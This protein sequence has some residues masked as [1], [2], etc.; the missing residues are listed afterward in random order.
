MQFDYIVIGG[1]LAGLYTSYLLSK[2][3]R[4]AL[5]ACATLEE[6]NSYFAQGGMA[7]V[8]EADDTPKSHF[9]DT[10]IAGRGLCREE[11]V[12]ILTQEAP[13]RIEEIITLGMHFDTEN[14]HLA[15]GLEGGHHHRR[16]LHAG[17]D[18]TGRMVTSFMTGLVRSSSSI[19]IFD[20]HFALEL[21]VED[22]VCYGV[23]T[24]DKENTRIESF[25]A[26]ATILATG[27][28]AALYQPTTNPPT[29]LGDGLA[30][31]LVAGAE[32]KDLE[33]VQFHPTALYIPGASSFLISEAVRGEGA[34]LYNQRGERFMLDKH[35]LA[36][37]APR[38]TVAREIFYQMEREGA[39][40]VT[41]SLRHLD[42]KYIEQR[43][44]T[45]AHHCAAT[46]LDLTQE[47]PVAPAAHY[48]V[49]GVA[50]DLHGATS[51]HRLYAV[52]E[53]ASTGVM[54]ANRLASNSLI[55]CLVF[56]RRIADHIRQ[57]P[58]GEPLKECNVMPALLAPIEQ[59]QNWLQEQGRDYMD[60]LGI[61]LMK[62][63][64]IVRTE[65]SLNTALGAISALR[66]QLN[67]ERSLYLFASVIDRRL[68]L[69]QQMV[70]A[71][72]NRRESRG[73][74]YRSDYPDTL[75]PEQTYHTTIT[76]EEIKQEF[77]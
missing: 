47:I 21:M 68:Y 27:G 30:M 44:P 3:G 72:L 69:A 54:G 14:G 55:E 16:I 35:P 10:I 48:T 77:I 61:I 37:L 40:Y 9:E 75:P 17:G 15:L 24:L 49:G 20:C 8:I 7:A 57:N 58:I 12:Q 18:A 71:A 60:Q 5:I 51:I 29:S 43:F 42:A 26:Q 67:Q 2:Y 23:H 11:A 38:D 56:G 50:T 22:G 52:G 39:G 66:S 59:E 46:G 64:G 65:R 13:L 32:L 70:V 63:V 4:V 28:A 76:Q 33:F 36:E 45:I 19:E 74:H 31:A 62:H 41:L 6:S 1:G 25:T 53:V 73:G 34:Y